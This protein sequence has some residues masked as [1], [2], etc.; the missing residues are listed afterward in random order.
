MHHLDIGGEQPLHALL[1]EAASECAHGVWVG[2]GLLRPLG[3]GAISEQYEGPNDLVAPLRLI[4][5]AQL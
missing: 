3:G 1:P 4:D 5:K 2:V